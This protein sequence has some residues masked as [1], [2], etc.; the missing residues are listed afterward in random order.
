MK[1][2][3]NTIASLKMPAGK[4]DFIAW[5][6]DLPSFGVRLRGDRKSFVVQYRIGDKQRRESLGDIRKI[7]LDDARKI[8]RQRFASVELG[9]DPKAQAN[10]TATSPTL[11]RVADLYLAARKAVVRASTLAQAVHYFAVQWKP[12]RERPIASISRAEVAARLQ[13][14]VTDH[15]RTSAS[16]ARAYLSAML[17]WAMREGLV[18]VN[19]AATTNN[20]G[21]GLPSRDRVLSD[22]EL[23]IVWDAAGDDDPGRIVKLLILTACRRDEIARL[24]WSEVDFDRGTITIRADR[25]KNHRAHSLRLPPAALDLLHAVPRRLDTDFVFGG[26][27]GFS[28]WSNATKALRAR[29]TQPVALVLHDLRRTAATGMAELGVV[30][31]VIEA[32]LNHSSGSKAGVAGIYNRTKYEPEVAAALARWCD[33]VLAIVEGRA[34]KVMPLRTA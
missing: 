33:H 24:S 15:G 23:K 14:I 11:A 18:D 32:A 17:S 9:V 19:V 5:D 13:E 6:T 34:P 1:L 8:A 16:R 30:P 12:F 21:A 25:S 29:M 20:P 26:A 28:G 27:Q 3:T 31:W 10:G 22:A 4:S 7:K 2:T